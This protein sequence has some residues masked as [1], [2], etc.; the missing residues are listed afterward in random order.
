MA[1][2]HPAWRAVTAGRFLISAASVAMLAWLRLNAIAMQRE[3]RRDAA[4]SPTGPNQG[5][6]E[7][8]SN[9]A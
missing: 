3:L 4:T 5:W 2:G 7:G 1:L 6:H 8:L 9:L